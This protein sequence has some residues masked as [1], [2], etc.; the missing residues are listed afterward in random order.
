MKKIIEE[1][2]CDECKVVKL[3]PNEGQTSNFRLRT[4]ESFIK[5]C[6]MC[7]KVLCVLCK[8]QLICY[9]SKRPGLSEWSLDLCNEHANFVRQLC[10]LNSNDINQIIA[11]IEDIPKQSFVQ[12]ESETRTDNRY[13]EEHI[14]ALYK[15]DNKLHIIDREDTENRLIVSREGIIELFNILQSVMEKMTIEK[16]IS[17]SH[18]VQIKQITDPPNSDL[19]KVMK[20][21][22]IELKMNEM[23]IN[24][25]DVSELRWE[26]A[27]NYC[28][29]CGHIM[30]YVDYSRQKFRNKLFLPVRIVILHCKNCDAISLR[31][32]HLDPHRQRLERWKINSQIHI[33]KKKEFSRWFGW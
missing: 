1:E 32:R 11:L 7:N 9:D 4:N 31:K 18:P 21:K 6:S 17:D 15:D 23:R 10:K 29:T 26:Y 25:T 14:V 22:L 12:E 24:L 33:A 5:K 30:E 2:F 20:N 3:L 8:K 28:S 27:N 13:Y 16:I 19:L